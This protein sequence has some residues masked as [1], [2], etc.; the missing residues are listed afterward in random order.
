MTGA[1]SVRTGVADA[2]RARWARLQPR[3]RR[4]LRRLAVVLGVVLLARGIVIPSWRSLADARERLATQRDLLARETALLAAAGAYPGAIRDARAALR[5]AAPRLFAAPDTLTAAAA[6]AAYAAEQA[7]D[8]GVLVE[9]QDTRVGDSTGTGLVA[10]EV[11]LRG[12]GDLDGVLTLLRALEQGEKLVRVVRLDVTGG[13]APEPP[14]GTVPAAGPRSP[15]Q[16][17]ETLGVALV[18]RGFAAARPGGAPAPVPVGAAG[19]TV[20]TAVGGPR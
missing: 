4:A 16:A 20:A 1:P 7:N 15:V 10:L 17:A 13:G 8:A 14:P 9:G 5:M 12:R 18:V 11:T 19:A 6:V 3:D 2:A